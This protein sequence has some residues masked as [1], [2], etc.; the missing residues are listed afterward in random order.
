[1]KDPEAEMRCGAGG[2]SPDIDGK[3]DAVCDRIPPFWPLDSLVA[4][5]PYLGF[6]GWDFDA[7]AEYQLRVLG[8]PMTMDR[9]WLARQLERGRIRDADL[10]AAR[11][12]AGSALTPAEVRAA[13]A[14]PA[15]PATRFL[16]YSDLLDERYRPRYSR[17]VIQ[18]IS[19]FCSAYYDLGQAQWSMP[20]FGDSLYEAWLEYTRID[21]TPG[22]MEIRT[23]DSLAKLPETPREAIRFSLERFQVP[24]ERVEDFL[25]LAL[26]RVG[27]WASYLRHLRWEA[28]LV[29]E[30]NDDLVHLLA[31]RMA[32]ELILVDTCDRPA[33]VQQWLQYLQCLPRSLGAEQARALEVDGLLQRALE[34]SQQRQWVTE[35]QGGSGPARAVGER[36]PLAQAAFCIDVRSEVLRR[37]LETVG[38]DIRTQGFAGF[39][40][41]P[42]EY[43]PLGAAQPRSHLPVLL[44]AR[45]RVCEA[46]ANGDADATAELRD[47]RRASLALS[48]AWKQ[49]KLSSASC[50][51][52]VE[53]AGLLY[54]PKLLTDSLGLTRPVP[55][56]EAKGLDRGAAAGLGPD[57]DGRTRSAGGAEE[58]PT[59]GIPR[60]DR[61]QLAASILRGMGLTEGFGRLVLL[62]GHGSSTVNN[63]HRAGLDCGACAG[64]TGEASVRI[65]AALLNDRAVRE[66]LAAEHG[67]AVPEDTWFLPGLHDTTT[68]EVA[69]LDTDRLPADRRGDLQRL[70]EALDRAGALARAERLGLLQDRPPAGDRAARKAVR[71]RAGDWAQ[72]RPEWGLAGN[73]AF[74]A[75]PRRRTAHMA[76][77]GRAFLHEYDWRRDQGFEGLHLIMTAPMVVANWI[78]L[79]YYGSTVDPEHLGAG[80]KVLH[81]VVG[82]R[83]GVLEGNGGDLRVGLAIQSL[84]DGRD[85]VHEPLRLSVFIEAPGEEMERVLEANRMVHDLVRHEWLHLFRIDDDSVVWRRHPRGGWTPAPGAAEPTAL[86]G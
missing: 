34:I 40:G 86:A 82:G 5:N 75:A 71:R 46:A 55:H 84:H 14:E 25:Y 3:I 11:E 50:F 32:W 26:T 9:R 36:R 76:L 12:L 2:A 60:A 16:L 35:L 7:A 63:P 65:A 48:K 54:L 19:S 44:P 59:A 18:Q 73:A 17:Y 23:A 31:I 45:Y 47:R 15:P 49:F 70:R 20:R 67:V 1:M 80:S 64:Q 24:V 29:G 33:R 66:A 38:G 13:A 22:E 37:A 4:T 62:A 41:V 74:I 43:Q 42:A 83:L 61:P 10:E 57:L 77:H 69:L 58:A 79:Q 85:W 30:R 56:P 72:V 81:N 52:F 6:V 28:E 68:D 8:R 78:N 53:S 39:F 27:G 51:S 21:R